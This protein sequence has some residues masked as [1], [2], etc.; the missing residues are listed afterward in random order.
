MGLGSDLYN[1]YD[2]KSQIKE[3]ERKKE[4]REGG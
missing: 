4:L 3:R 2:I 1:G